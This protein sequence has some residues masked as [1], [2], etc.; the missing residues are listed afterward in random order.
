MLLYIMNPVKFRN[1]Q[2]L[3]RFHEQRGDK[4]IVFSDNIFA[5]QVCTFWKRLVTQSIMQID[6]TNLLFMDQQAPMREWEFSNNFRE[7]V[8]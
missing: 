3:I 1:C 2:F 7:A 8:L 5:L 6:L 4:I